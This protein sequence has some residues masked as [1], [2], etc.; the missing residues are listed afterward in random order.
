MPDP[1]L[2]RLQPILEKFSSA[3][4][5]ALLP[6]L[7]ATQELFGYIPESA[8][9]AIAI[10]LKIPLVDVYGVITFYSHFHDRPVSKSVIHVCNDP[11]CALAGSD[12]YFKRMR[13]LLES[14][15]ESTI[16]LERAPCLGLCDI[17]PSM[18]VVGDLQ[19]RIQKLGWREL[20]AN[21]SRKHQ[22][23][24]SGDVAVLTRNCGK[25]KTTWLADYRASGGYAGSGKSTHHAAN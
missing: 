22:T 14:Q 3:G 12:G 20:V 18:M 17:A 23:T 15:G 6:S 2:E 7:H 16:T 21:T 10:Q 4:R 13:E 19:E 24:V 25:G 1:T 5:T 8:A 9:Q 11:V